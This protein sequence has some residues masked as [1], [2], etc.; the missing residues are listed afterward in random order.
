MSRIVINK[1]IAV[2]KKPFM[3]KPIL[4]WVRLTLVNRSVSQNKPS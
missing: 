3:S 2:K 4:I 1:D